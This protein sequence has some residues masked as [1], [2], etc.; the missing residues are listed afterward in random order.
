[1]DSVYYMWE[2]LLVSWNTK[3]DIYIVMFMDIK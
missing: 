2:I 3:D 1:M